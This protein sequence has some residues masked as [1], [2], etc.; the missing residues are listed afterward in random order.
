MDMIAK[1]S[2][3]SFDMYDFPHFV[4]REEL[5][6]NLDYAKDMIEGQWIYHR[7]REDV[8]RGGLE[9]DGRFRAR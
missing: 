2:N 9:R 5:E 7:W 1:H 3:R 4:P 6:Y 8:E